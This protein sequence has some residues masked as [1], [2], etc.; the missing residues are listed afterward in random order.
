MFIISE[1]FNGCELQMYRPDASDFSQ[2]RRRASA[3]SRTST[4]F[5]SLFSTVSGS[6]AEE[7]YVLK[8]ITKWL[9]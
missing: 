8:K 6:P 3:T 9:N 2:A 7:M 1:T 5:L 4:I